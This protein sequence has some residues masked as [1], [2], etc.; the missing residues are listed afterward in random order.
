MEDASGAE[1]QWVA[2]AMERYLNKE[3]WEQWVGT[4]AA[5]VPDGFE[6]YAR[7]LHRVSGNGAPEVRWA[8][9]AAQ[10]G[11]VI[12]PAVQFHRL[13]QTELYGN[14]ILDGAVYGRPS[15]GELDERQLAALVGLLAEHSGPGQET[16]QAVWDGWGGFEPG[17][18]SIPT[19]SG[20]PLTVAGGLRKY[21]VFRGTMAELAHPP[22]FE[23]EP[24]MIS[25]TP[26][27]AWPADRRWCLATEIDFDS[28][29]VGGSAE[30]IAAVVHSPVLEA[31]EVTPATDLS[32]EG[33]VIN[34]PR[35]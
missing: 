11:T 16:F 25:Q 1:G 31:V 24:G 28:T 10:K 34:A 6:A 30:L 3:R 7:I 21:W 17:C 2:D 14:A 26:N 12:H 29:V 35:Q 20:E 19:G 15:Q 33:D 27:L 32:S 18:G 23:D 22:W 5:T 8:D 13:A 9:V 4:V